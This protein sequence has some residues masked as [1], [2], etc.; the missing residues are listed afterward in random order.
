MNPSSYPGT[1]RGKRIEAQAIIAQAMRFLQTAN[2]MLLEADRQEYAENER[3][4][5]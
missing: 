5:P 1:A 2:D 4:H 3:P